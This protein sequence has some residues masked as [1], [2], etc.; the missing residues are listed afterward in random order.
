MTS[1]QTDADGDAADTDLDTEIDTDLDADLDT[2]VTADPQR[3]DD[4]VSDE[5]EVGAVPL[6]DEEPATDPTEGADPTEPD[7]SVA[8]DD[9]DEPV[10]VDADVVAADGA[11]DA[12][13]LD[14][15]DLDDGGP[16]RLMLVVGAVVAF[17]AIAIVGVLIASG[18]DSGGGGGEGNDTTA[19]DARTDV[20]IF[21]TTDQFD[22][23]DSAT[24]LGDF[25]PGRPW[26]TDEGVGTWGIENDEAR[27][28]ESGEFRNHAVIGLGQGDGGAQVRV[29]KVVNGVGLV[30]RYVGP[31]NYWAVVAVP[32]V[33]TWN[34]I[35]VVDG[36][37]EVVGNTGQSPTADGTTVAVRLR[38]DT[39]EV[40]INGRIRKTVVDDFQLNAG[41]VGMTVRGPDAIDARFDDFVAGL[42][43]G[44]PL[45]GGSGAAPGAGGATTTTAAP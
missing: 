38:G 1:N 14:D 8:V 9:S 2:D 10:D 30:F 18:G 42:P 25:A 6:V 35:K 15:A 43:G 19:A 16:S 31:Y 4:P 33:A 37:Q 7:D 21:G 27:L 34:L 24:S 29:D 5:G 26:V 32:E 17:V 36:D 11:G 28:V 20:G 40:I 12:G 22:R 41:K 45:R 44:V 3:G 23:R 13:D 39:V